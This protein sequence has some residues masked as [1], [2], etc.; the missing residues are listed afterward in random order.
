MQRPLK[1]G[2]QTIAAIR[3]WG[4]RGRVGEKSVGAEKRGDGKK[5][6]EQTFPV[7]MVQKRRVQ[8]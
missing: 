2:R 1:R 8:T 5:K 3:M 4:G 6:E 7:G